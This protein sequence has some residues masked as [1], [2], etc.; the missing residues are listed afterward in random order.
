MKE[1]ERAGN[2]ARAAAID[3]LLS[4]RSVPAQCLTGPGP[5]A[6]QVATAF[7]VA[8]RAPDHGRMQPWRFRI[9]RGAARTRF[10][11]ALVAA[12]RVREPG[13]PAAQL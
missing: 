13:L 5:D 12:A 10:S 1:G 4:R 8:L 6:A 7:D 3:T 11:A 2:E 9:I